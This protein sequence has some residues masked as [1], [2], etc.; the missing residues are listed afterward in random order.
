MNAWRSGIMFVF[1]YAEAFISLIALLFAV[2][3]II[4]VTF[5]RPAL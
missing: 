4:T 5:T 2:D 3:S 1:A